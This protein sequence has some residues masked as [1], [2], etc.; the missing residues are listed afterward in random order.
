ME[1]RKEPR[2]LERR[3]TAGAVEV[4][5]FNGKPSMFGHGAVF[6]RLSQNL[7][8]FVECVDPAAF[9]KTLQEADVRALYNHDS[10]LV[11]GRSKSGT[12][13]LET[14]NIGLA[15]R[16]D[17]PNTS[18]ANDLMVTM[19]RGDVDQSSFA[20]MCIEDDWGLTDQGFPLR[21]LL[22]VALVDVSPVT[23]PAYLDADSGVGRMAALTGLSKR[24]G[25]PIVDLSDPDAILRA[26]RGEEP[27]TEDIDDAGHAATSED[28]N[29]WA[30]RRQYAETL[31][32]FLRE[33]SEGR[34]PAPSTDK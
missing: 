8:G 24:S 2:T 5:D 1:K 7:G 29:R 20:F 31:D 17:P 13:V 16:I 22:Q 6:N 12:L 26:V 33:D 18:Y 25:V 10:N 9:D 30:L 4:R 28:V 27:S 19:G 11:L 32:A 3:F 21:T 23:Y 15:Y 14:D 34:V